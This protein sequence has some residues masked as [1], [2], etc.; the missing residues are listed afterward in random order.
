MQQQHGPQTAQSYLA[1]KYKLNE[2][3]REEERRL[4]L[5]ENK[6]KLI[7]VRT[8]IYDFANILRTRKL[9][10]IYNL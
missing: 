4:V 1:G 10:V 2:N 5:N 9:Y 3:A 6:L 7:N 8:I